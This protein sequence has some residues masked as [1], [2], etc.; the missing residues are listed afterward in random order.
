MRK[1]YV[2]HSQHIAS[3]EYATYRYLRCVVNVMLLLSQL[4]FSFEKLCLSNSCN[5]VFRQ[6][7]FSCHHQQ[8][9]L[10]CTKLFFIDLHIYPPITRQRQSATRAEECLAIR[11]PHL[12]RGILLGAFP[13]DTTSE[14]V[15]LLHNV[16][17]VLNVKHGSCEYQF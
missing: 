2:L 1:N 12:D 17:L 11:L 4:S 15:G 5:L 3:F 9:M 7:I 10:S 16:P 6:H 14:L 8:C 13:N